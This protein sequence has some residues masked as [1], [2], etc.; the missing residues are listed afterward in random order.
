MLGGDSSNMESRGVSA[1]RTCA[2]A[3]VRTESK[4]VSLLKSV[5]SS[6]DV[7]SLWSKSELFSVNDRRVRERLGGAM[8]LEL[9]EL[10]DGW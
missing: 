6:A 4:I 1:E 8:E 5:S 10:P 7:K 2:E 9:C 3:A